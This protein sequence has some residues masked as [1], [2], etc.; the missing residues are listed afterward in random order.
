MQPNSN[1]SSTA[2]N[3]QRLTNR[4]ITAGADGV[5]GI[6]LAGQVSNASISNNE[7]SGLGEAARRRFMDE[8]THDDIF[9]GECRSVIDLGTAN[10]ISCGTAL[11][12]CGR[13]AEPSRRDSSPCSNTESVARVIPEPVAG[14]NPQRP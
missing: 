8:P 2:S 12:A 10:Q 7:L 11:E 13:I 4:W 6:G 3:F 5:D 9:K 1:N 14:P